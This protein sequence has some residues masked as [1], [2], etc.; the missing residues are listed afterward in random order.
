MAAI[1]WL[2]ALKTPEI[3]YLTYYVKLT[4]QLRY[5]LQEYK[6]VAC[7]TSTSLN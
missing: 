5:R 2:L 6:M 1:I 7:H 4:K 3:L